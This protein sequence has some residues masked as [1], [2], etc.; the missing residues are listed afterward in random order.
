MCTND[1][2]HTHAGVG[3][4]MSCRGKVC[5]RSDVCTGSNCLSNSLITESDMLSRQC[6]C[7]QPH[8]QRICLCHRA[9]ALPRNAV[10]TPD[11]GGHARA[12]PARPALVSTPARSDLELAG[13]AVA[14]VVQLGAPR[15]HALLLHHPQLL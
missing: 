3:V 6:T 8:P 4:H 10:L 13:L 1:N 7:L 12:E 14:Q 11:V 2:T 15:L 9:Y 5:K